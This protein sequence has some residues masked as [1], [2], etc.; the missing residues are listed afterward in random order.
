M[1][2]ARVLKAGVEGLVKRKRGNLKVGRPRRDSVQR[3]I[4]EKAWWAPEPRARELREAV[5]WLRPRTGESFILWGQS[6]APLTARIARAVGQKGSVLSL[7]PTLE[8]LRDLVQWISRLGLVHI[9]PCLLEGDIPA[10]EWP[11]LTSETANGVLLVGLSSLRPADQLPLLRESR[12]WLKPKGR[13]VVTGIGTGT[14]AHKA[15]GESGG[16]AHPEGTLTA[17]GLE[18]LA[19]QAGLAIARWDL[20][21][22][23]RSFSDEA[24]LQRFLQARN[25]SGSALHIKRSDPGIVLDWHVFYALLEPR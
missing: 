19:G 2:A 6:S 5:R 18:M 22:V 11:W 17:D 3:A 4:R 7:E 1:S 10:P 24:S 21:P 23:P 20:K 12:R 15:C 9:E 16:E 8:S 14:A 13:V 25:L